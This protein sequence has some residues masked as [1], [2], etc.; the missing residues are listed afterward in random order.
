MSEPLDAVG[1]FVDVL[2]GVTRRSNP[3]I[4]SYYKAAVA[5]LR[6]VATSLLTSTV[7][8]ATWLH[9]FRDFDFRQENASREF[10]K[11]K[12]EFR[13]KRI[14]V[15]F[16]DMKWACGDIASIYEDRLKGK[17]GPLFGHDD[18]ALEAERIFGKLGTAD[19]DMLAYIDDV[20]LLGIEKFITDVEVELGNDG[21]SAAQ[22]RRLQ[23]ETDTSELSNRLEQFSDELSNLVLQF[24]R[25]ARAPITLSQSRTP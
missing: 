1:E 6:Q 19:S 23:F 21:L 8:V 5:D 11:L 17:L 12:G 24:G 13:A 22:R 25:I 3:V 9:R 4:D 18:R 7:N 10:N 16:K 15:G 20:I 2:G 14:G